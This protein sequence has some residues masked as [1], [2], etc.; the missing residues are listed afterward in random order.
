MLKNFS[1]TMAVLGCS[2]LGQGRAEAAYSLTPEGAGVQSSAV[3]PVTTETFTSF[4]A[5]VYTTLNTAVGTV[6]SDGAAIVV[7][8][9]YGGAGGTGN[10]FSVGAQSG[11]TTATLALNG[12]QSYFGFWWSAADAENSIAFISN[13]VQVASYTTATAF[14]GL[15]PLYNGNPNDHTNTGEQY[16]YF[17]F[18][19]TGGSKF[20]HVVFSN[21]GTGTGFESDNW[22]VTAVPEPSSLA[23][24][25]MG[26][27]A[28]VGVARRRRA[29]R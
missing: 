17:N 19:G 29:A 11:H 21:T 28:L 27:L 24:T 22:S 1:W 9:Q 7:H 5:G 23:L 3:S 16:A 6:T 2:A 18:T 14:A 13:G 26:L 12:P 10:Y 8:N 20:D 4:T 25:G 15:G